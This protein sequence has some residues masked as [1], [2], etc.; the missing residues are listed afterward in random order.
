MEC[1]ARVTTGV[2][3]GFRWAAAHP[4]V[5][6]YNALIIFCTMTFALLFR[7]RR[8]AFFLISLLWVILGSVNGAILLSRMTPFTLY[9]LQN[10][11][12]GLTIVTTYYSTWQIV[13]IGIAAGV[14]ALAIIMIFLRSEKWKNIRYPKSVAA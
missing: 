5:F 6:L 3:E 10:F 8:F 12:D 4:A 13:L 9:D 7:R 1:F 2:F 14:G 11:A